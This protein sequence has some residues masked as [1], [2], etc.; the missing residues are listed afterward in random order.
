MLTKNQAKKLWQLEEKMV[1]SGWDFSYLDG[2]WEVK[3]TPWDYASVIQA[4]LK[5]TDALLDMGTGGGEFLLTLKHP[6]L[7]TAATEGW[8]PNFTLLQE[9]L[10]PL[11]IKVEFVEEDD[12][13]AFSD[14]TFDLI[15]NRH[16]S[17]DI[18]EVKRVLKP[19]GIFITQQVATGNNQ[20]LIQLMAP[21]MT[22]SYPHV[23]LSEMSQSLTAHGFELLLAE[24]ASLPF[25]FLDVGAFVYY[26]KVIPWEFP[27]F[28]VEKNMDELWQLYEELEMTG[29]IASREERFILI[30]KRES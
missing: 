22:S 24:E 27:D 21:N 16:E 25:Y 1:F 23:N 15:I 4:Y 28:S 14:E 11:G 7:Q 20:R 2:R 29:K 18:K 3:Q 5:P 8:L 10:V 9:E 12:Q 6:Y 30:G 26:A 17:F 19:G 13:L